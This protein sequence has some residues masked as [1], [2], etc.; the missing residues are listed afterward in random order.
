[1]NN[2]NLKQF[3][4]ENKLGAY[5]KLK[6]DDID[7]QSAFVL[8]ADAARDAGKTEFEF[9]KGSGKIHKVTLKQDIPV[10]EGWDL[11]EAS[12]YAKRRA[13]ERDY[14]P[15]K[16]DAPAKAFKE[17]K[18][19]YFARRKA[20]MKEKKDYDKL[21]EDWGSSDQFYMDQ[22]IHKELGEP[23][24]MPSP[25][26][27]DFEAAVEDAVDSN[28]DDWE[29]YSTRNGREELITY[30]KQLYLKRY[31]P[32]QF[33]GFQQ[34][35]APLDEGINEK[36]DTYSLKAAYSNDAIADMIVNLNRYEGN[37]ELIADLENI[38][39]QRKN[40]SV[41]EDLDV[42]HQD[43]EPKMLKSTLYRSA[44]MAAMLYKE[45]DKYD[46]MPTEVDFPNWWQAKLIKAHDYLT[47]AFD[48]LDGEQ[49]TAQIDSM[50]EDNSGKFKVG[51]K[52]TY[53][54][55]PAEITKVNKEMTG[56]ITYNVAYN[57]GEGR[58]K[59]TNISNKGGEIKHVK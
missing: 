58:T 46:D 55:H 5:S 33:A 1:M 38:L 42:G 47:S 16:K 48:Y 59:A 6:E 30:A 12:D 14:Q 17:P 3:I 39:K 8:A 43:D 24:T 18:N 27:N 57:K 13:A 50:M 7:E 31:F 2:F 9:P 34:L 19:D 45:L 22:S 53:L 41:S 23:T 37:E 44:K 4:S 56:D 15:S 49:K 32:K 26:S 20:D 54:G 25:F 35:F 36:L 52:V 10:E 21:N 11:D 28:W 29:E 51:D 40:K